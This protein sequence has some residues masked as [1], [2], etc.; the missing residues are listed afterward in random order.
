MA[1]EVEL[2]LDDNSEMNVQVIER[3]VGL[4]AS[5]SP[6]LESLLHVRDVVRVP[7]MIGPEPMNP[8][9]EQIS[10]EE[11]GDRRCQCVLASSGIDV[12]SLRGLI[13]N[14]EG[15]V[16]R[17]SVPVARMIGPEP[18]SPGAE[19]IAEEEGGKSKSVMFPSILRRYTTGAVRSRNSDDD[20]LV[21]NTG[22]S[23]VGGR[24]AISRGAM[25]IVQGEGR[26]GRN[27]EDQ[28]VH[29]AIES[30]LKGRGNVDNL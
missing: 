13:D 23:A 3:D 22:G 6:V 26:N 18:M 10:E 25:Q 24:E 5:K 12:V 14:E 20:Q 16:L 17:E 7:R 8:G 1:E 2:A 28:E 15:G 19:E 21:R 30:R 4:S 27:V 29:I 11:T 9:A